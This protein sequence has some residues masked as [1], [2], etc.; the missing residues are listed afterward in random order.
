MQSRC[1]ST[2]LTKKELKMV[3][4]TSEPNFGN[5]LQ[6]HHIGDSGKPVPILYQ[7][8]HIT[9]NFKNRVYHSHSSFKDFGD[10]GI[11]VPILRNNYWIFES[12]WNLSRQWIHQ[13]GLSL[14]ICYA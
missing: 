5:G 14:L 10:S 1:L 13:K 6:I 2:G 4:G 12:N 3:I 9:T 7:I 8:H 11:P